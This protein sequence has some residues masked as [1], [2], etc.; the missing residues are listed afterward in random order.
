MATSNMYMYIKKI[1]HVYKGNIKH[2]Y[3]YK[4]DVS[5]SKS[6]QECTSNLKDPFQLEKP[7][8]YK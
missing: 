6:L 2:V 7:I 3:V 5:K 4:K 1:K 8:Y